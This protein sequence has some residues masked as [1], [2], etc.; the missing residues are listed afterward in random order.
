MAMPICAAFNA[1]ASLT[2]SPVMATT[3][4]AAFKA[5]TIFSFC[6]GAIRANTLATFTRS[7]SAVSLNLSEPGSIELGTEL[8]A[9]GVGIEAG[10]F[11]LADADALLAA[12]WA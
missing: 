4:P 11:T 3:W 1:G 2:P 5:F 6:C 12:P 9:A 8:L 10:L 7:V